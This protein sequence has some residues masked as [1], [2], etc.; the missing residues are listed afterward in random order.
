MHPYIRHGELDDERIIMSILAAAKEY[1]D[2]GILEAREML[3]EVIGAIDEYMMP[4]ERRQEHG[5]ADS[6]RN[7]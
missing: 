6:I 3:F 2:G 5:N 4:G 1:E 7:G